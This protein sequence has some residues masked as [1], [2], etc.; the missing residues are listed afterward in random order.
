MAGVVVLNATAVVLTL[1]G[2]YL[3]LRFAPLPAVGIPFLFGL[4]ELGASSSRWSR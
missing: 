2:F 1:S 4:A 3:V